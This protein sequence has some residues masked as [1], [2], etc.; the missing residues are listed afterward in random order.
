MNRLFSSFRNIFRRGD[1]ENDLN[2][3]INAHRQLLADQN[4]AAGMDHAEAHRRATLEMGGV[5]QV[6][7][8]V[9]SLRAGQWLE[10]LWQD[11]RY[12]LRMLRKSP[13]FAALAVFTLALGIGANTAMFSV[14]DAVLLQT[15]PFPQ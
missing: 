12:A 13:A 10:Q 15:P 4:I 2:A 9:R 1:V 3:E 11:I 5:E 6:K 8:E 14:I 7:E